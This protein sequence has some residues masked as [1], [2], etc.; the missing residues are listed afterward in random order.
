MEF[1]SELNS[2]WY[3]VNNSEVVNTSIAN[4]IIDAGESKELKIIFTKHITNNELGI[5]HNTVGLKQV[6]DSYNVKKLN[7]KSGIIQD[8]ESI[9]D[10]VI[11]S[12]VN[13]AKMIIYSAIIIEMILAVI[14]VVNKKIIKI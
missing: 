12:K 3:K 7:V 9:S 13:V 10:L 14:Y 2:D 6:N 5:I 11:H 8:T 1:R 4:E